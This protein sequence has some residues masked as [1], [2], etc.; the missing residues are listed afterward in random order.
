M[1]TKKLSYLISSALLFS[2]FVYAVDALPVTTVSFH[3]VDVTI[4]ITF[5]EEA[6]PT[7]SITHNVTITAN[8]AVTL[9]NFTVV[10]EASVNSSWQEIFNAQDTFSKPLPMSYSLPLSLPQEANGPLQCF[11]YVNT[12]QSADYLSCAFYSTHVRILTFNELLSEYNMISAKYTTLIADYQTLT[13]KYNELLTDQTSLLAD[14]GT[15]L[16]E[17][18]EL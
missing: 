4:E 3:G 13:N 10:I 17:H 6:H 9:R 1:R 14:Y 18:N 11:I 8:T 15:L 5:P 12:T 7:E 16:N 2:A